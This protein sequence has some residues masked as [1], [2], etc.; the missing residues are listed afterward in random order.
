M[1]IFLSFVF[2]GFSKV[3]SQLLDPWSLV[4]ELGVDLRAG[5]FLVLGAAHVGVL[6]P[7]CAAHV[8]AEF[9]CGGVDTCGVGWLLVFEL[10]WIRWVMVLVLI[11]ICGET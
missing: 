2:D 1:H 8:D 10:Y 9:L 7:I 3:Q 11:L 6:L 5:L 4:R